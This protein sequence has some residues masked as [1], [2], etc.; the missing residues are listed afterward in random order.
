VDGG[1]NKRERR[2]KKTKAY[3]TMKIDGWRHES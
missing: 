1:G 2:G 3:Q